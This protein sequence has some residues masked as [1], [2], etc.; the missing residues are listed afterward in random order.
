[1]WAIPKNAFLWRFQSK[2]QHFYLC[3]IFCLPRVQSSHSLN[4]LVRWIPI[5][6]VVVQIMTSEVWPS[7][8]WFFCEAGPLGV[9]FL[10]ELQLPSHQKSEYDNLGQYPIKKIGPQ[11]CFCGCFYQYRLAPALAQYFMDH[12]VCTHSLPS[13]WWTFMWSLPFLVADILPAPFTNSLILVMP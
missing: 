11:C 4:A 7:S 10:K 9:H 3:H 5:D 8:A 1:M 12:R 13:T 6:I 2:Q